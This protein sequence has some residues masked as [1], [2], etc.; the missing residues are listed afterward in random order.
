MKNNLPIPDGQ[1]CMVCEELATAYCPFCLDEYEDAP[2]FV[3][4]TFYCESHY[5]KVVQTGNCCYG[6]EKIYG[7][8][9]E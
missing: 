6:S 5:E 8:M 1:K 3:P 9:N 2:R 4:T 7:G